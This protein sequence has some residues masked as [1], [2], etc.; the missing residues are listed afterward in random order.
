MQ[1]AAYAI[2]V[3][4]KIGKKV[5]PH[6]EKPHSIQRTSL[7]WSAVDVTES[8][9]IPRRSRSAVSVSL[10][11]K[12]PQ[13]RDVSINRSNSNQF[14][15]LSL[16]K[17]AAKFRDRR[18]CSKASSIMV[19]LSFPRATSCFSLILSFSHSLSLLFNNTCSNGK[20]C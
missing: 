6:R 1:C 8:A 20:S 9:V 11:T 4:N 3:T 2:Q 7:A 19:F 18:N 12:S 13:E 16:S 17:N 14:P 15:L 10:I 5:V